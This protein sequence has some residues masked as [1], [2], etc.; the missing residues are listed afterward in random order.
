[1]GNFQFRGLGQDMAAEK[2]DVDIQGTFPPAAFLLPVPA[3]PGF[4]AV[5]M[6][7]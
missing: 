1:M 4:D 3:E 2:E 6:F 5:D 7:Q